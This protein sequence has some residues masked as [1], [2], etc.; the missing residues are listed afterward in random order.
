MKTYREHYQRCKDVASKKYGANTKSVYDLRV[1]NTLF[2]K[3]LDNNYYDLIEKIRLKIDNKIKFMTGCFKDTHA[4]RVNEWRDI[5]EL[6]ELVN[7]FMPIVEK[8]IFGCD[9]KIEFLHPYRNIPNS[10]DNGDLKGSWLWHYDDCPPEFVKLFINLN[11][12]TEDSG[13]LKYLKESDGT[14]PILPS[15]RP[16]PGIIGKQ[17]YPGSRIPI[18]VIN[19]KLSLGAE[20]VNVTGKQGSYAVCTPNI[21]HTA[22]CPQVGVEPRDVLFFFI[23]PTIKTY[24]SYLEKTNSYRPVINVKQYELN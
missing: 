16:S 9:A 21:Y 6:E 3:Y 17:F 19:K 20:I 5:N 2:D 8:E 12:V 13:C 7:I 14:I 18:E 1:N 11:N 24:N 15:A 10:Y 4:I 23:R 22:S